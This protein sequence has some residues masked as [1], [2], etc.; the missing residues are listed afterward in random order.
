MAAFVVI[1]ANENVKSI[2]DGIH[3]CRPQSTHVNTI[4][5]SG[6]ILNNNEGL[7][8]QY[9]LYN[10][11]NSEPIVQE[12][13]ESLDNCISNQLAHLRRIIAEP[14]ICINVFLIAD[15]VFPEC[16]SDV[17]RVLDALLVLRDKNIRLITSL[18]VYDLNK[19]ED[20]SIRPDGEHVKDFISYYSNLKCGFKTDLLYLNNKDH[21]HAAINANNEGVSRMLCDWF[22]LLSNA[23]DKYNAS[24]AI[25]TTNAIFS[26]GYAELMFSFSEFKRYLEIALN[27]DVLNI[28]LND[29]VINELSCSKS[30]D[31]NS[32]PFGLKD[33]RNKLNPIFE[34]IAFDRDI[35][36][37]ICEENLDL[38]KHKIV[39][40]LKEYIELALEEKYKIESDVVNVQVLSTED[41]DN[42]SCNYNNSINTFDRLKY[43]DRDDVFKCSNGDFNML[44]EKEK[45]TFNENVNCYKA[46][47]DYV[48][49][50]EFK[51]DYNKIDKSKFLAYSSKTTELINSF[52]TVNNDRW[53]HR[54]LVWLGFRKNIVNPIIP[55][56]VVKCVDCKTHDEVVDGQRKV[57]KEIY[58]LERKFSDFS[59]NI[60]LKEKQY[61]DAIRAEN[62]FDVILHAK[63]ISLINIQQLRE[64]YSDQKENLLTEVKKNWDEYKIDQT[65][66]KLIAHANFLNE[67]VSTVICKFTKEY[68][69]L[70]FDAYLNGKMKYPF[71][72]Y[73][74]DN[75]KLSDYL[76]ALLIQ[77]TPYVAYIPSCAE[78]PF[79]SIPRM[80]YTSSNEVVGKINKKSLE[81]NF[82][83]Y[84]TA[85]C[86]THIE[87]KIC[88][89][90]VFSPI[91]P[92]YLCD[93]QNN[94]LVT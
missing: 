91:N 2:V 16:H 41:S 87:N 79:V 94:G 34:E 1:G 3:L 56:V 20:V 73:I 83:E 38:K 72:E 64:F 30:L 55:D 67:I 85:A 12:T 93:L 27:T 25:G 7:H 65:N 70:D 52:P 86:S 62:E 77:S 4:I 82:L 81:I 15:F 92:D 68:Q 17:K 5:S 59:R 8:Y 45:E 89:F 11:K 23:N 57:F 84:V 90:Q 26:I 36:L 49:S 31:Y 60:V 58:E 74:K 61:N 13:K 35:N 54:L 51:D 24:M 69:V 53:W 71:I 37:V 42:P 21:H 9:N 43:I 18:F 19:Y 14:G 78:D 76:N 39:V 29:S 6:I 28:V 50:D 63:A 48:M 88:I 80:I 66:K 46:L 47:L 33:K 10:S 44:T 75:V 32:Y 40:K 22:M